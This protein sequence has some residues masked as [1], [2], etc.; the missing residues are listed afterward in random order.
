M[1]A[2]GREGTAMLETYDGSTCGGAVPPKDWQLIYANRHRFSVDKQTETQG[3]D[4]P[5]TPEALSF[6]TLP[7]SHRESIFGYPHVH[8]SGFVSQRRHFDDILERTEPVTLPVNTSTAPMLAEAGEH[9]F[10]AL[11]DGTDTGDWREAEGYALLISMSTFERESTVL[12]GT[13]D[14]STCGEAVLPNDWQLTYAN[15][16]RFSVDM[17]TEH[18]ESQ[19]QETPRTPE[20][21]SFPTSNSPRE[22]TMF[23]YPDIY[24]SNFASPHFHLDDVSECTQ[25]VTLLLNSSTVPVMVEAG[26]Y[27]FRALSDGNNMGDWR[28][29]WEGEGFSRSHAAEWEK[30]ANGQPLVLDGTSF[31]YPGHSTAARSVR[32]ESL[33]PF[34]ERDASVPNQPSSSDQWKANPLRQPTPPAGVSEHRT[35][36][37]RPTS[38]EFIIEQEGS[39]QAMNYATRPQELRPPWNGDAVSSSAVS[40][41][42]PSSLPTAS[43][44]DPSA[45]SSNLSTTPSSDLPPAS[46]SN[47]PTASSSDLSMDSLMSP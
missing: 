1:S 32:E 2:F 30:T 17:H 3:R 28:A 19:G 23:N 29:T 21:A 6:S 7:N 13:Y 44:D 41:T 39:S 11:S 9:G 34:V 27:G 8:Y 37:I 46:S 31:L 18:T 42:C 5:R 26:E 35:M 12:L 40:T 22:G 24:H 36:R 45:P 14:G 43:S 25:P 4:T 20:T 10:R 47:L 33:G 15:R 38:F 16:R